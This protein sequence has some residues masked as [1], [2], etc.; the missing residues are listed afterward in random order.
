M[1]RTKNVITQF[2]EVEETWVFEYYLRPF[3]LTEKLEG[4]SVNLH[5]PFKKEQTPSFFLF[6]EN[7][8]FFKDYSASLSGD[9]Y[10]L[11]QHLFNLPNKA[12]AISKVWNQYEEYL[13][14][15]GNTYH[16]HFY[17]EVKLE[18][19]VRYHVKEAIMRTW[20]ADDGKFWRDKYG[21]TSK[22]LE[23]HNVAPLAKIVM[24]KVEHTGVST[25]DIVDKLAY[26]Y[27]NKRGELC[28]IYRP[29]IK[30][31]KFFRVRTLLQGFEQATI[32]LNPNLIIT[33]SLKDVICYKT[34]GIPG[35]NV[36]APQSEKELISKEVMEELKAR[37]RMI[38]T[39]M[40]NDTTGKESEAL[41][42]EVYGL[43]AIGLDLGY[44]DLSDAVEGVGGTTVRTELEKL[45]AKLNVYGVC[46]E[47][48][49][50][51]DFVI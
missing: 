39:L 21:I 13:N 15:T 16:T 34:L 41:Y 18:R 5:S 40:D 8:Y 38:V 22:L 51:K 48:L 10:S 43:H 23:A 47:K 3:G 46:N 6:H 17:P 33:K 7:R 26:G 4:Q 29:G 45:L 24:N 25:F 36:I 9:C 2:N 50:Q 35:W 19:K 27:Y 11:V 1:L 14:G 42:K 49:D 28:H 20:N 44:K 12:E 32:D 30:R 37:Y 31:G